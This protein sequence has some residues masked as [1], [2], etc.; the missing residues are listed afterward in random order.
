MVA[1]TSGADV[2]EFILCVYGWCVMREREEEINKSK[3]KIATI[4]CF[5]FVNIVTFCG[6]LGLGTDFLIE[7]I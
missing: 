7:S 1:I 6:L 2:D 3:C 4:F 5:V